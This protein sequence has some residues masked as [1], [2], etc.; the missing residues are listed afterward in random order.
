[1]CNSHKDRHEEIFN[2]PR[3]IKLI[4]KIDK[5]QEAYDKDVPAEV[6]KLVPKLL[7]IKEDNVPDD[8]AW[9]NEDDENATVSTEPK[10]HLH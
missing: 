8:D 4:P 5:L 1:M 9:S 3:L 2:C 10:V 7:R 6:C